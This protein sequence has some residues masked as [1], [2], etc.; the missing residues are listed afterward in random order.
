MGIRHGIWTKFV[1]ILTQIVYT[2]KIVKLFS[3]PELHCAHLQNECQFQ[4][5]EELKKIM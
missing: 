4:F 5:V 3:L 1:Q 2:S